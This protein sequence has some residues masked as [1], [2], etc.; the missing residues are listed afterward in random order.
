MDFLKNGTE[1]IEGLITTAVADGSREA[2]VT[3]AWEIAR[4]IR[5]PSDFTLVLENAHLRMADGV[6]DNMFVN[7]HHGTEL[8]RTKAGT[9]RAIRIFGR[10]EAVLDGGTYNGLSERNS[11]KDG[12][13]P[14]WKNNLLL[15]TNVEGFEIEGLSCKNQRWWALCFIYCGHGTIRNMDFCSSDLCV[16]AEGKEYHGLR[17]G[18]Y[19][20]VLVKN[21][22]GIDLRQGCHDILIE[23]V[24]GFCEDD[25]VALTALNGRLERTFAVEGMPTDIA[26]VTVRHIH[27]SSFCAN[28]RL[29]N[30]GGIPL[31]DI[32]VE[33]VVDTSAECPH[34]DVGIF[35]VRIGDTHLYGDRHAT[36]DETYRITVR[37]VKSRGV[38]AAVELAGDMKDVYIENVAHAEGGVAILDKRENQK[39]DRIC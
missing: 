28:V 20:D 38:F 10:G 36:G 32:Y 15:F 8:G 14:I 33:D 9:D 22:D 27:T 25:S 12:M 34:M 2:T 39:G 23:N 1:Y 19:N 5:L 26:H 6:F 4:A 24:T 3:G 37:N 31:H 16:D 21:S 29:L 30:Q 35:A 17:H 18:H 13:P 7:A 11:G